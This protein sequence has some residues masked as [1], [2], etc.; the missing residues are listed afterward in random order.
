MTLTFNKTLNEVGWRTRFTNRQVRLMLETLIEVWSEELVAG[1]KIEIENFLV[2][3]TKVIDRG[4][5]VQPRVIRR[6]VVKGSRQLRRVLSN[7][8][9]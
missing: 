2:L 3:E 5:N 1:G 7:T 6:V 9:K 8:L 4:E